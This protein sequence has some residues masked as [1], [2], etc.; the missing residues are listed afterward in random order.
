MQ[1]LKDTLVRKGARVIHYAHMDIHA[2]GH[3]KQEDLKLMIRLTKPKY[4]I[5]IHGNRFL[6]QAHANLAEHIGIPREN[7]FVA[8]N[9]QVMEFSAG[10]VGRLTNEKVI[11]DYV[12]VDG[13]GVGDVSTVVLRDRRM[14]AEDGMFVIIATIDRRT[15]SLIGNPDIISRGFIYLR[16]NKEVIEKARAHVKKILHDADPKSPAFDDYIKNKLRND[17]GQLLFTL[18]KRRPMILPV[19]I[20]V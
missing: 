20:E 11:T 5:P 3:A 4:V 16:E 14:L 2:G 12:M 7:V 18:T 13:L 6:L 10:G 17:V 19:V 8:D 1:S 9:G 15:G